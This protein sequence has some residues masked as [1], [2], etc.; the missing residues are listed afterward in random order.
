MNSSASVL[1]KSATA[2]WVGENV[3]L[4]CEAKC[5]AA[6]RNG[7][8]QGATRAAGLF[9][10][11]FGGTGQRVEAADIQA[12]QL[13]PFGEDSIAAQAGWRVTAADE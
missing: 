5:S 11:V 13:A 1:V 7:G 2:K 8:E 6:R 10:I 3:P 12:D 9:E 4:G